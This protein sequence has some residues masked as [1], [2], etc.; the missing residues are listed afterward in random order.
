[1]ANSTNILLITSEFPP[2]PGGIG[3]HAY[4]LAL[5]LSNSGYIITVLT[6]TRSKDG[7]EEIEFD[8]LLPFKI[9]RI[10][11]RNVVVLTYLKR[12]RETISSEK[13]NDIILVSG[14]FSLWMVNI[15]KLLTSKTI[16]AIVHGSELQLKGKIASKLTSSGLKRCSQIIAVSNYTKNLL[17]EFLKWKTQVIPNGFGLEKL[18]VEVIQNK[19]TFPKLITVGNVTQRKGQQNVINALP[20]LLKKW[21]QLQ[22]NI[23]GIPTEKTMILNLAKSI[24]VEEAIF[25]HGKVTD[26][27]KIEL[28]QESTIFVMLS[29]N[30]KAG[31]VEGFGIAILEANALGIPAIG[32]KG[33][34]IEDAIKNNKSGILVDPKNIDEVNNAVESILN[35]YHSYCE[36]AMAWSTNFRWDV[37][38]QEYIAIIKKCDEN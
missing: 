33:C 21:P 29:E 18:R 16:I 20:V 36:N 27:K 22:Y 6:D 38:I 32:S 3:N 5:Y 17:P 1:M 7:N 14:K 4:N 31:D 25:L 35:N 10:K 9:N 23:V 13:K 8:K 26:A 15:L 28:V 2:Q 30:T 12:I 34:G 37:V 24:D 11:R 19:S